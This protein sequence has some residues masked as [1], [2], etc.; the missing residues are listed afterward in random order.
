MR[1]KYLC[2][3]HNLQYAAYVYPELHVFMKV[4]VCIHTYIQVQAGS[5]QKM[6][7]SHIL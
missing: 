2:K 6:Q 4:H 7:T 5:I 3:L 1:I